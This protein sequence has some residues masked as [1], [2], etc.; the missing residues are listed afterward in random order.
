M[1]STGAAPCSRSFSTRVT[2]AILSPELCAPFTLLNWILPA[3]KKDGILHSVTG[4]DKTELEI[5]TYSSLERE[6][7]A[8]FCW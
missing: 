3:W 2:I 5:K 4:K 8:Q 6:R 7:N 1:V